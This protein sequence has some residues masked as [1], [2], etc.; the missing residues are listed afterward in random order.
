M[1]ARSSHGSRKTCAPCA[2][3]RDS[4]GGER[5]SIMLER[6]GARPLSSGSTVYSDAPPPPFLAHLVR[7][8][9]SQIV[10][11]WPSL[12]PDA[13]DGGASL[14]DSCLGSTVTAFCN[15]CAAGRIA[16]RVTEACRERWWVQDL[17]KLRWPRCLPRTTNTKLTRHVT[18]LRDFLQHLSQ[19]CLRLILLGQ[20]PHLPE[21]NEVENIATQQLFLEMLHIQERAIS[22]TEHNN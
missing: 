2:C 13:C 5:R 16:A 7:G 22:N 6:A 15:A 1:D 3:E 10:A 12:A 14:D 9:G 17:R 8:A 11:A 4:E 21:L 18:L 19:Q 20:F